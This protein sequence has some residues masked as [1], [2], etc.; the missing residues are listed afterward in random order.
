MPGLRSAVVAVA[1]AGGDLYARAMATPPV[2]AVRLIGLCV[3][4]SF[5]GCGDDKLQGDVAELP[6]LIDDTSQEVVADVIIDTAPP[7]IIMFDT[8]PGDTAPE[9]DVPAPTCADNPKPFFCPCDVNTQCESSYCI[10]VDEAEVSHRC[11]RTCQTECPNGW[12][13]KGIGG[14]GDPVFI[15]QPPIDTLCEACEQDSDCQA[16]GAKCI[17]FEDGKYCG[18]DCQTQQNSCPA[19]Y[20]CNEI[21][22]DLGQIDAY[23]CVRTSGSCNCPD[24]TDYSSDPA[25]CGYCGNACIYTHGIP[26]CASET[27]RLDGCE[28]AWKNLNAVDSDGC[29]YACTYTSADDWPDGTCNSENDCD[30]NCDGIDGDYLRAIFV[31]PYGTNEAIG[32]PYDPVSSIG[33]ALQLAGGAKDHIYVAAGG[34]NESVTLMEGISIFGGY[35]PDGKWVRNVGQYK[36]TISWSSGTNSVR[37]VIANG[38]DAARTVLDGVEVLSGTN[39]NPSGSSYAIWVKDSTSALEIV[40]VSVVG[41]AG[42][43]GQ[44]GTP[45]SPGGDGVKGGDASEAPDSDD[46]CDEQSL[47]GSQGGAAGP[48]QCGGGTS[49]AGGGGGAAGCIDDSAFDNDRIDPLKG[50]DSA[51]GATGGPAPGPGGNGNNG[52]GGSNGPNGTNGNAGAAGGSTDGGGLW[53]ASHGSDGGPATNGIGGGGGSGGGGSCCAGTL[54]NQGQWG[55]GGGG[56]GSGGCGGGRGTGGRGGGSSFGLFLYNASPR[57][58]NSALGHKDGGNAGRGGLGGSGGGGRGGGNG[59]AGFDGAGRGGNGAGGGNGG[60]GG[61]GGGGAGGLAFGL[62][63]AGSSDPSCSNLTFNPVG[64]TGQGGIGGVG[65]D[66]AGNRGPDGASGERNASSG[67]CP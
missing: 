8:E 34:Y 5:A 38:I 55:G 19:G 58:I 29:E 1:S 12:E 24:G 39:A 35:S 61:H 49:A 6:E 37:T 57:I 52:T 31:A 41:G 54:V 16:V 51:G 47:Y 56:G 33:R 60:R 17:T 2:R 59:I 10:A 18:R 44:A 32:A 30:Q 62:Y 53:Q 26:G 21:I 25:N 28:D 20:Q 22:N 14:A 9:V 3:L 7:E 64:T 48:N 67:S 27:C 4:A 23:Q 45:G 36:T 50:G 66:E 13:C 11:S 46:G 63:L 15:C 40:S 65:G 43:P 42:G